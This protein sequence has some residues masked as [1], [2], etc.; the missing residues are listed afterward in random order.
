MNFEEWIVAV[1][2]QLEILVGL[3]HLDLADQTWWDWY[4]EGMSVDAAALK[5]LKNE[6]M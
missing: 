2:R 4:D 6:G 5:C 1:D 3:S